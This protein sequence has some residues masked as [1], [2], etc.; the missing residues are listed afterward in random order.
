VN[1]V[2]HANIFFL[3]ASVATVVFCIMVTMVLYQFYKIAQAVR[4]ILDRIEAASEI[5]ADDVAH[6]RQL[7]AGGGLFSSILS[8][9]LGSKKR[10]TRA[11]E[12]TTSRD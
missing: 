9:I 6:V 12:K 11:R 1:E 4:S 7:I 2:L 5:M 8:F 10:S 3:I